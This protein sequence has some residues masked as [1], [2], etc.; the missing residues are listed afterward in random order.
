MDDMQTKLGDV[1]LVIPHDSYGCWC[2]TLSDV[3]YDTLA[4]ILKNARKLNS[5]PSDCFF[6]SANMSVVAAHGVDTSQVLAGPVFDVVVLA[7][8]KAIIP[9][10]DRL[11]QQMADM[12]DDYA[13]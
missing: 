7:D 9:A 4:I 11:K 6:C 13:P 12:P 2:G 5:R 8:F 1:V 3:Y 10:G